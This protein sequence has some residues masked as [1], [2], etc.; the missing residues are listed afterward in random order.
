[1]LSFKRLNVLATPPSRPPPP[2]PPQPIMTVDVIHHPTRSESEQA[3]RDSRIAEL[4][5]ENQLV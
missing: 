3:L 2:S 4:E 5:F 1:M